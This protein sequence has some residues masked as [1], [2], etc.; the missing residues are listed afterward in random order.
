MK[1]IT[2]TLNSITWTDFVCPENCDNFNVL[3]VSGQVMDYRV[4]KDDI[5][6]QISVQDM[7]YVL[8]DFP[9]LKNTPSPKYKKDVTIGYGKLQASTGDVRIVTG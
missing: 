3:N 1:I 2:V 8:P 9:A 6:T 4:D 5:G 7:Q